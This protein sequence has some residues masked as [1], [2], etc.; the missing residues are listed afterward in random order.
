MEGLLQG[1]EGIIVYTDDVLVSGATAEEHLK[2]LE[3]LSRLEKAGLCLQKSKCHFMV[4]AVTFSGHKVDKDGLHPLPD[5][6][7]A[8]L[9]A[10]TPRNIQE[11]K[12]YLGLFSYYSKFLPKLSTVLAPL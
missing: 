12:S 10:P 6:I 3:V 1:I 5:K 7:N 8:V 4:S 11:L 9:N 2:R